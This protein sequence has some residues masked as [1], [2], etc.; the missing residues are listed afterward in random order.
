MQDGILNL[1]SSP[2]RVEM[3]WDKK[4]PQVQLKFWEGGDQCLKICRIGW[5]V[6]HKQHHT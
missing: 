3:I 5:T 1:C 6:C 4:V 2:H